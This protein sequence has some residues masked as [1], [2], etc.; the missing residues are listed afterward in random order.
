[1]LSKEESTQKYYQLV[2]LCKIE[3]VDCEKI[4]LSSY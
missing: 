4:Q 3:D 1:M 2:E